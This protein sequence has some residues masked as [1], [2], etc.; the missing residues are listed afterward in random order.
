MAAA[1]RGD[2]GEEPGGWGGLGNQL[3]CEQGNVYEE[4]WLTALESLASLGSGSGHL[5][6][7]TR[8]CSS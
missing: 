3:V 2:A 5:A 7:S 1:E 4:L 8:P 6:V